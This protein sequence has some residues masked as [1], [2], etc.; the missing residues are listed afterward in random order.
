MRLPVLT[1]PSSLSLQPHR[2][3]ARRQDR[4]D[5]RVSEIEETGGRML[6]AT[7][8]DRTTWSAKPTGL[9]GIAV[10]S[11]SQ[12]PIAGAI[13][14][15]DGTSD[16]AVA[17]AR[18]AYAFTR[19]IPGRYS[20]TISDTSLAPFASPRRVRQ[21]VDVVAGTTAQL[22]PLPMSAAEIAADACK[23]RKRPATHPIVVGR[24]QAPSD[25]TTAPL[26]LGVQWGANGV[27]D[28]SR[29]SISIPAAVFSCAVRPLI[30]RFGCESPRAEWWQ[31]PR[32]SPA[33][34]TSPVSSGN[35]NWP[36]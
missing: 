28:Q 9:A 20:A 26:S 8:D 31:T 18:G 6:D 35:R 15:L 1:A 10:E 7:W 24:V 17:N 33:Q 11:R 3:R 22:A 32:S 19:V 16:T 36:S 5:L 14:A 13:V 34:S 29:R 30:N 12:S 21:I 2:N 4:R 23:E 25:V 27:D